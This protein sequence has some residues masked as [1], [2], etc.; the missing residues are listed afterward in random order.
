MATVH[1]SQRVSAADDAVLAGAHLPD[2]RGPAGPAAGADYAAAVFEQLSAVDGHDAVFTSAAGTTLLA[3][4]RRLAL[5]HLVDQAPRFAHAPLSESP[6]PGRTTLERFVFDAPEG[7]SPDASLAA[8]ER[9]MALASVDACAPLALE[10]SQLQNLAIDAHTIDASPVERGFGARNLLPDAPAE[11]RPSAAGGAQP[12]RA[13]C[14]LRQDTPYGV[15]TFDVAPKA[16]GGS[17]NKA[18]AAALLTHVHIAFERGCAPAAVLLQL[19]RTKDSSRA[20]SA[21]AGAAQALPVAGAPSADL[22]GTAALTRTASRSAM[23]GGASADPADRT[24]ANSAAEDWILADALDLTSVPQELLCAEPRPTPA[25]SA[26]P[27]TAATGTAA[28]VAATAASAGAAPASAGS[29]ASP[30]S[31]SAA[32][33]APAAPARTGVWLSAYRSSVVT[34]SAAAAGTAA[35]ASEA[36][37]AEAAASAAAAAALESGQAH[38]IHTHASP[39]AA[40]VRIIMQGFHP[41]NSRSTIGVAELRAVSAPAAV[42]TLLPSANADAD[43]STSAHAAAGAQQTF[44]AGEA[45]FHAL[46]AHAQEGLSVEADAALGRPHVAPLV[47]A[48]AAAAAADEAHKHEAARDVLQAKEAAAS[49]AAPAPAAAAAP[50]VPPTSP[51][52]GAAAPPKGRSYA[53]A[54]AAAKSAGAHPPKSLHAHPPPHAHEQGQV[55]VHAAEG[56]HAPADAARPAAV[57]SQVAAGSAVPGAAAVCSAAAS[58]VEPFLRQLQRRSFTW[59][60]ALRAAVADALSRGCYAAFARLALWFGH[61]AAQAQAGRLPPALASAVASECWRFQRA[62]DRLHSWRHR[63]AAAAE[64]TA[65]IAA[66]AAATAVSPLFNPAIV[67]APQL[68]FSN[69]NATVAS[70]ST[71]GGSIERAVAVAAGG[72][73]LKGRHSWSFR[74]DKDIHGDE[75]A[76]FGW[77]VVSSLLVYLFYVRVCTDVLRRFGSL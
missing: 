27:A 61:A 26:A 58:S 22:T 47:H 5:S 33:A 8:L 65:G 30:A 4:S 38:V 42:A 39:G 57:P 67:P 49:A 34:A 60:Q 12:A 16:A 29:A 56:K 32:A 46:C 23:P 28:S 11:A 40:R 55:H 37:A 6:F 73:P 24:A 25:G 68:V 43:V 54:A 71:G 31:S 20:D 35:A 51:A 70:L 18:D 53:A 17:S 59:R 72:F 7:E 75:C 1:L 14:R 21:A 19:A 15:L 36:A 44:R 3:A 50:A 69:G 74:L 13:V 2:W 9:D 76:A 41:L 62:V 10:S 66:A 52:A 45:A 63:R 48:A 64:W 77:A